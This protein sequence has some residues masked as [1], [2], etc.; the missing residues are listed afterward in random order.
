V[1]NVLK[2]LRQERSR[3]AVSARKLEVAVADELQHTD[4]P[5]SKNENI[6][7]HFVTA[8]GINLHDAIQAAD[9]TAVHHLIRYEWA[10]RCLA[11]WPLKSLLDLATGSGYGASLHDSLR[12]YFAIIVRLEDPEFPHRDVFDL[13]AEGPVDYF[14]KMNP[15]V[16]REPI[17]VENPYR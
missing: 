2:R 7:E 15:V 14:L 8:R 16:C 11:D 13:L 4:A 17:V 1:W 10:A 5:G 6:D 3:D 12:R 9:E